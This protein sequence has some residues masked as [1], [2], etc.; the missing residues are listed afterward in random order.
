MK[1]REREITRERERAR[2][3]EERESERE[4]AGVRARDIWGGGDR[5]RGRAPLWTDRGHSWDGGGGL[6]HVGAI[7]LALK[8]LA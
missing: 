8:P 6:A 5:E 3:R 1:A 7:G 4:R 2:E